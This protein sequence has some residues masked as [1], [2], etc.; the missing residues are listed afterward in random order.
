MQ[1]SDFTLRL[2]LDLAEQIALRTKYSR[3]SRNAEITHM[4]E[5]VIDS[6]VRQDLTTLRASGRTE[7]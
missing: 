7:D 1:T 2:P 3:R 6:S 5:N 4:L